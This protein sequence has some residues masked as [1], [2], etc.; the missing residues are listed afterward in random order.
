MAIAPI[1]A[2]PDRTAPPTPPVI[3]VPG[4]KIAPTT[5]LPP[6]SLSIA[7]LQAQ[8]ADAKGQAAKAQKRYEA[9]AAMA[10][11]SLSSDVAYRQAM[12]DEQ[13]LESRVNE[14][15]AEHS[16]DLASVSMQQI[17]AKHKV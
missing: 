9:V 11:Q 17:E 15:R 12:A 14:L 7:Q 4:K 6:P 16:P 8:L 1:P 10:Q 5:T 2:S 3:S 13:T